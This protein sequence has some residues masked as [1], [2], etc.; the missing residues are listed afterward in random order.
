MTKKKTGS[1]EK[2]GRPSNYTPELAELVCERVATNPMGLGKIC[3]M[4][5]DSMPSHATIYQWRYKHPEFQNQYARAKRYQIEIMAESIDDLADEISTYQDSEGNTRVDQGS[6][7]A[8]RLKIDG[9]KWL[10]SKLLPKTY[11]QIPEPVE[12]QKKEPEK[13]TLAGVTCP[14]EASRIYQEFMRGS[15]T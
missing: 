9:R 5:P 11:G 1:H 14:I 7:A 15:S 6:V 3:A 12:P 4:Y 10:A 13:L 2:K 8:K